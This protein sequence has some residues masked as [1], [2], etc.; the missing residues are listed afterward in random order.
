ME[1]MEVMHGS[2]NAC[3]LFKNAR[4]LTHPPPARQDAPF[5]RQGRSE[6]RGESYFALCVE[7]LRDAKTMVAGFFNSLL[8]FTISF[9]RTHRMISMKCGV[10]REKWL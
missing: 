7:P 4:R 6:Q 10:V 9:V 3:R 5:H 1:L 8:D 2:S